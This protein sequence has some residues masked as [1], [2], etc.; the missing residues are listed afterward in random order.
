MEELLQLDIPSQ[1]KA[2][3]FTPLGYTES[4]DLIIMLKMIVV[5][6][7]FFCSSYAVLTGL[8]SCCWQ[9]NVL[10]LSS[11]RC[12]WLYFRH[13]GNGV[14][15]CV[16]AQVDGTS[17]GTVNLSPDSLNWH[18]SHWFTQKNRSH[19]LSVLL[20][21]TLHSVN[22]CRRV[23]VELKT[24]KMNFNGERKRNLWGNTSLFSS[25]RAEKKM[26]GS[27]QSLC[28]FFFL[29]WLWHA[30]FLNKVHLTLWTL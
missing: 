21:T 23:N 25:L 26:F 10:Q 19:I 14:F 27:C 13:F 1:I 29:L 15:A 3:L 11:K 6:F 22:E 7:R 20:R 2:C 8:S 28:V 30:H 5:D 12:N 18:C 16:C 24:I 4:T 17:W 9:N